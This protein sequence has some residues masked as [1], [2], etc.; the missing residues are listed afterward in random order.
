MIGQENNNFLLTLKFN[1][2][3]N[4]KNNKKNTTDIDFKMC[5]LNVNNLLC[6]IWLKYKG[7]NVKRPVNV[8]TN[9]IRVYL[10]MGFKSLSLLLPIKFIL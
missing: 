8:N 6:Q 10:G 9:S 5:Y 7:K 1:S 3:F 4:E 2:D